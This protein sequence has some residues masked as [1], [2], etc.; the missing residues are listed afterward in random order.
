MIEGLAHAGRVLDEKSYI[1]AAAR[2]ADF[3]LGNLRD[4]EGRLLRIWRQGK[5]KLPAYLNDY[6]FFIAGLLELHEASGDGRWLKH[7]RELADRMIEDFGNKESGGF[8]LT[9]AEHDKL[10][11]RDMPRF[12]RPWGW[13]NP[14]VRLTLRPK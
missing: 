8:F 12:L 2:A 1:K 6:A 5:A 14:A 9:S 4:E 7:A 11:F 10:L 3:V 13:N